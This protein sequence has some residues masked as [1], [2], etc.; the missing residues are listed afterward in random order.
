MAGIREQDKFEL[1]TEQL[2]SLRKFVPPL[3]HVRNMFFGQ[4]GYWPVSGLSGLV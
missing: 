1:W 2:I 3:F 4:L